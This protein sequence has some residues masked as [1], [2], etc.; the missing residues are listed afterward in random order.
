MARDYPWLPP[1]AVQ[2]H[3]PWYVLPALIPAALLAA[4]IPAYAL[5][6]GG[7]R[8][9]AGALALIALVIIAWSAPARWRA[10]SWTA[11]HQR[12]L[13]MPSY[14]LGMK[15]RDANPPG[16][17]GELYF[18]GVPLPTLVYYSRTRCNFVE[19]S[20]L[21]HV[22][23]IGAT[24]APDAI[25]YHDLVLLDSSA[26]AEV[27]GNLDHEWHWAQLTATIPSPSSRRW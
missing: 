8:S 10:I 1:C 2:T 14:F 20:E 18:A 23:L 22:E 26:R 4:S 13:S 6:D 15:A 5:R 17:G 7:V 24:N 11:E 19:T 3:L 21:A 25:R 12:A 27:I 16:A 9:V